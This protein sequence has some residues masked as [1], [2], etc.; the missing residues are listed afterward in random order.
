MK[1]QVVTSISEVEYT[2]KDTVFLGKNDEYSVEEPDEE[3][4]KEDYGSSERP[5]A[6]GDNI[7]VEKIEEIRLEFELVKVNFPLN[8]NLI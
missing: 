1:F 3:E 7:D 4:K 8:N 5:E 2:E 6:G